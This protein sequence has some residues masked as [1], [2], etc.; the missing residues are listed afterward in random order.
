MGENVV[1][2]EQTIRVNSN[3]GKHGEIPEKESTGNKN[4]KGDMSRRQTEL[5][6]RCPRENSNDPWSHFTRI[7][8]YLGGQGR[9]KFFEVQV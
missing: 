4:P 5:V 3:R 6:P 9:C 2:C 7:P 8:D 1:P